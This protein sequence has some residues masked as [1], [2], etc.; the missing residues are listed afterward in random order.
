MPI[1]IFI[2]YSHKDKNHKERLIVSLTMLQRQGLVEMWHD[3]DINPGQVW[4]N[5]IKEQLRKSDLV[6]A[7]LSSDF[8]ASNYIYDTELNHAF[9]HQKTIIPVILRACSWRHDE[10]LSK[11]QALPSDANPITSWQN[12]DEAWLSVEEGIRKVILQIKNNKPTKIGIIIERPEE[13]NIFPA[14]SCPPIFLAEAKNHV[15]IS[16]YID[17]VNV[18]EIKGGESQEFQVKIG[19]HNIYFH[20]KYNFILYGPNGIRETEYIDEKSEVE[21]H[22]FN[23]VMT[24]KYT[25]GLKH[26]KGFWWSLYSH[27]SH[28]LQGK[29]KS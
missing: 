26:K 18:G 9:E 12:N 23:E 29:L 17:D 24:Y 7:L 6:L 1:K 10:R 19:V 2:I 28:E 8:I 4:D 13:K 16:I 11:F 22:F 20:L 3:Q 5:E 25:I 27:A 15:P 21:K 14:F